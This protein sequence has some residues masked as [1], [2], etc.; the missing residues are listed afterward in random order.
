MIGVK[1][2]FLDLD[3][4]LLD[5]KERHYHCY[6]HILDK[7]GY[8]PIP[9]KDYWKSK[10]DMFN[11][12]ALLD[13]SGAGEIYD[14]FLEDWLSMIETPQ[15][16]ALDK[17]QYGAKERLLKW[18]NEG[19]SLSLVTMRKNALGL[20]MQLKATG[21]RQYLDAVFMCDHN[22]GGEGKAAAVRHMC[23]DDDIIRKTHWIGDTEVDWAAAKSLGCAATLLSN[24]LRSETYLNS[25]EG[26]AVKSSI[27][28]LMDFVHVD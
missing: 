16:L 19:I 10:R 23:F 7:Y 17:V 24:G 18:K 13:L 9:I 6:K 1:Q 26:V 22:E 5:G 8:Q 21:L 25:L 4:P 11:R 3:G 14:V 28:E 2:I 12:R 20:D 27:R 15:M